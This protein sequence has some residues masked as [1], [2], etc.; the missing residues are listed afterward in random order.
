MQLFMIC[1]CVSSRKLFQTNSAF[2]SLVFMYKS[3]M[4]S[5]FAGSF[6][7]LLQRSHLETMSGS[8]EYDKLGKIRNYLINFNVQYCNYTL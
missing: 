7:V 5:K 8:N 6:N 4:S 3:N 2:M 1:K